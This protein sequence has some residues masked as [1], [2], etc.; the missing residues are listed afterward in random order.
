[1]I[2][3]ST[4][5]VNLHSDKPGLSSEGK[6]FPS[7]LVNQI[8]VITAEIFRWLLAPLFSIF[9]FL[10]ASKNREKS[11]S[12]QLEDKVSLR[13]SPQPSDPRILSTETGEHFR[14]EKSKGDGNCL[15]Y[16]LCKGL[17]R[18]ENEAAALREEL[19]NFSLEKMASEEEYKLA[20]QGEYL[21]FL[22]AERVKLKKQ[23]KNLDSL[24]K[25]Q[26]VAEGIAC[27]EKKLKGMELFINKVEEG[28]S[29]DNLTRFVRSLKKDKKMCG[30]LILLA[31]SQKYSSK[32]EIFEKRQEQICLKI[33]FGDD[34]QGG[35]IH[36]LFSGDHYDFLR[37][38][39]ATG[40]SSSCQT[41]GLDQIG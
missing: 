20:A 1:M 15:F 4:L 9:A 8:S 13:K 21:E 7:R 39:L 6:T 24:E 12:S 38:V 14:F 29:N 33:R 3:S 19:V 10:S 41:A 34:Q 28:T 11:L 40:G 30:N 22:E 16:S 37:P 23:Q 36:L 18:E 2:E 5:S 25:T 31:Y 27:L 26:D 35:V 32:I 17:G